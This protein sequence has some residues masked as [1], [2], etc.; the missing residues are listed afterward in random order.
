MHWRRCG[1]GSA[2]S[3]TPKSWP[4]ALGAKRIKWVH[5]RWMCERKRMTRYEPTTPVTVSSST[6]LRSVGV[7]FFVN[8]SRVHLQQLT[9][10]SAVLLVF[11]QSL[12]LVDDMS[13][14]N[15]CL[16]RSSM[17]TLGSLDVCNRKRLLTGG[18]WPR[19]P[20][21]AGHASG[22]GEGTMNPSESYAL[23]ACCLVSSQG[24]FEV[25]THT[26]NV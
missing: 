18:N 21:D 8:V 11:K 16:L 22:T 9:R 20:H 15:I 24:V 2:A 7:S 5:K 13:S 14:Q 6:E 12:L 23:W 17:A 19:K 4:V 25:K 10:V 3:R 1:E 26:L